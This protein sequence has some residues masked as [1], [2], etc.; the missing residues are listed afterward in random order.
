ETWTMPDTENN[1]L[2]NAVAATYE[3]AGTENIEFEY[4]F[5]D[6]TQVV[7]NYTNWRVCGQS[8]SADEEVEVTAEPATVEFELARPGGCSEDE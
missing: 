4:S 3:A 5:S 7:H 6:V 8:P 2:K 1:M